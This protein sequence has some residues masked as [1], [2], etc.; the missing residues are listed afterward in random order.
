MT[1]AF[2]ALPSVINKMISVGVLIKGIKTKQVAVS[3]KVTAAN[4]LRA[5]RRLPKRFNSA[6]AMRP[7]S[8]TVKQAP[9]H[10]IIATYH[11]ECRS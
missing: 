2:S 6:S 3:N 4:R 8:S 9:L 10:G 11:S 5:S 1:S 7:P